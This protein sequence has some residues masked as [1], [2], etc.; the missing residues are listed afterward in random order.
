MVAPRGPIPRMPVGARACTASHIQM[1]K[2]F[3]ATESDAAL[4]LEDDAEISKHL[5]TDLPEIIVKS[6]AGILNV[7]R[8]PPSG[9]LKRVAVKS[10]RCVEETGYEV[11]DLAGIHFGTAGYVIDRKSAQVVLD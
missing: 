4:I 5:A 2:A 3:L 11:F 10:K 8:Q 1:L 9:D 7:N 6:G